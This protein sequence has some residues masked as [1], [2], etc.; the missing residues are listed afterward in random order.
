MSARAPVGIAITVAFAVAARLIRGVSTGGAIAGAV[1]TFLLWIAWP[2][3]FIPE[4]IVFA[5]TA[6][7]TVSGSRR[8]QKLGI[9]ERGAGRS[10]SQVFANLAVAA[11]S[12]LVATFDHQP[13]FMFA[14]AGALAE[15]AA[16]TVSSE[17]GQALDDD[18]V[19]ITTFHPVPP[20]TD[21]GISIV[22]TLAGVSAALIVAGVA[23]LAR[24]VP[25]LGLL[26]ALLA[27]TAG[28]LF[29]SVLG[30][31]LERR[32]ILNNDQVNF[33][34]TLFAAALAITIAKIWS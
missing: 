19:L 10:A 28:M 17:L 33:S 3:V 9:A 7:A 16:D 4:L 11:A 30:A 25:G 27:G 6:A 31:T 1:V 12:A 8:K 21:G 20:G 23:V 14:C 5:L 22:G 18:P 13:L 15:A 32:R 24:V 34:S 26:V 29:D 2:A